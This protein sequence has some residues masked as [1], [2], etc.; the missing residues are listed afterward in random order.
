MQLY[1]FLTLTTSYVE[2]NFT[3]WPPYLFSR[4]PLKVIDFFNSVQLI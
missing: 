3:I 2:A 4:P 1:A